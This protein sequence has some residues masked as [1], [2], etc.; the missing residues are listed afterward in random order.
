MTDQDSEAMRKA[1]EDWAQNYYKV[2]IS[3]FIRNAGNYE[4]LLIAHG[5]ECWQAARH[6]CDEEIAR[7]RQ[8]TIEEC[9]KVAESLKLQSDCFTAAFTDGANQTSDLIAKAI[10]ALARRR[11]PRNE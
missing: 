9:A 2:P 5:W 11:L 7:V 8:Q 1:F 3:K 6:T 10:Q 4:N